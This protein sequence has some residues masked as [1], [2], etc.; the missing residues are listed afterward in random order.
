MG[1]ECILRIGQGR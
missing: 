1:F